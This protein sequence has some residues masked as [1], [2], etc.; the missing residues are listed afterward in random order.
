M[1]LSQ[2]DLSSSTT[3]NSADFFLQ[4]SQGK[5]ETPP[6]VQKSTRVITGLI[7]GMLLGLFYGLV[8]QFINSIFS[9]GVPFALYPFGLAGNII[10]S[11][12]VWSIIGV[13][14]AWPD[15]AITGAIV[16]CLAAAIAVI[17]MALAA[18]P[19]STEPALAQFF[20]VSANLFSFLVF[21]LLGIPLMLLVRWAIDVQ[22]ELAL[23]PFWSWRRLRA[24]LAALVLL[25]VAM[26]ILTLDDPN[27]QQAMVDMHGLIQKG[28]TASHAAQLPSALRANKVNDFL[29][30]A[31][32]NY[33][34]EH[35]YED[36]Y[37]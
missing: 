27:V 26:S 33:T 25:S 4:L 34:L 14:C 3:N 1:P 37:Q 23:Q 15:S 18:K 10:A 5:Q 8:T 19:P 2:S 6:P 28:L 7:M 22:G 35:T 31:I 32:P 17:M 36:Q 13:V 12:V 21:A 11:I 30:H 20:S 24:P 29:A 9:P 16:G